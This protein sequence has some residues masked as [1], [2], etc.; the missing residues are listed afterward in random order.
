VLLVQPLGL[1]DP[2]HDKPVT[3]DTIFYIASCTKSFMATAVM[4]LAEDGKLDLDAPVKRYLPRFELPD[5]KLAESITIRDLLCH[6]WGV[7]SDHI[8]FAEAFPG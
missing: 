6:R 1:R 2:A 7:D 3:P 5:A 4:S 8:T